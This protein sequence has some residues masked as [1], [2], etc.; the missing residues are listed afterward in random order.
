MDESLPNSDSRDSDSEVPDLSV[1]CLVR[2]TPDG[3]FSYDQL[4]DHLNQ[5][6]EK[7]IIAQEYSEKKNVFHYHVVF[8]TDEE[9]P[10]SKFRDQFVYVHWPT[11]QRGFGSKQWNFQIARD[12]E[13]GVTYALKHKDYTYKGYDVDWLKA[14]E[15]N[16]FVPPTKADF[17]QDF[18]QLK[19]DFASSDMTLQAFMI[20]FIRLKAK[21]DQ[22]VNIQHAYQYGLSSLIR[23]DHGTANDLVNNFLS[24]Q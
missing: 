17:Q 15:E 23:R 24:K 19:K 20:E 7:W 16:S 4:K 21:H 18:Y 3:H 10:K 5:I 8:E 1:T 14:R 9:D 22:M 11:R 6:S 13:Q 2:L 12:H